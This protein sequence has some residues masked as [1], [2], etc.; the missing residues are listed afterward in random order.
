MAIDYR[1]TAPR[2]DHAR[3]LPRRRRQ[4]RSAEIAR[5][6]RSPSACP[7][8]SPGLTLALR[9]LRLRQVHARRTDGA[10]DR[11][12]RATAFP[13]EDDLA[14]SLLLAQPR[15]ARWPS[16]AKIFLKPDGAPLGAGDMLVQTRSRRD[17]WRRS[18]RDGPARFY[19]GPIADE[20]VAAAL[21]ARR[22]HDAQRR[23]ER[24]PADR[25]RAG[26]AAPIA[27]TTSLSMPPPSSGGVHLDRDAQHPRRLSDLRQLRRRARR[28]RCT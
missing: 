12:R 20:I 28:A 23:S 22:R 18:P 8:R 9:T 7:A 25:A 10:G 1:E 4:S 19:D 15:L 14:D 24:L 16:A 27:A 13:V 5:Q 21:D 26:R 17:R 2:R 3:H 6:P 11:A